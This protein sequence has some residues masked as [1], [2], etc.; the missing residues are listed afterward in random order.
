MRQGRRESWR[1]L[2]PMRAS[3]F[4]RGP[5]PPPASGTESSER[6]CSNKHRP[7]RQE[8][9]QQLAASASTARKIMFAR[10][11]IRSSRSR[12]A[13]PLRRPISLGRTARRYSTSSSAAPASPPAT[14]SGAA[15]VAS[16]TSELDRL[17]P[18]FEVQ[19][20]QIEI[21]SDP[22]EFYETLKVSE[23]CVP[24]LSNCICVGQTSTP[25]FCLSIMSEIS[26]YICDIHDIS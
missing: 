20:T 19:P 22:S 23:F 15:M 14:Q 25:P 5:L 12:I 3:A 4:V 18:R 2:R 8:I 17:S 24:K 13:T 7:P 9:L 16:L 6:A 1:R 26:C 10:S 21:L 11:A